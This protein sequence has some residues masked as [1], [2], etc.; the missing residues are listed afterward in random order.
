MEWMAIKKK[1]KG[2]SISQQFVG[3][4]CNVIRRIWAFDK[5]S[6]SLSLINISIPSSTSSSL[7]NCTMDLNQTSCS[8]THTLQSRDLF[9]DKH[10]ST[11]GF[12][13]RKGL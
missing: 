11:Y 4:L 12:S 7:H 9:I 1:L 5:A 3:L 10:L 8:T 2:V 13:S 6:L